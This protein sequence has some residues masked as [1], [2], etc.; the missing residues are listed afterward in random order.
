METDKYEVCLGNV[1][2]HHGLVCNGEILKQAL[3]RV[4]QCGH[5]CLKPR[6]GASGQNRQRDGNCIHVVYHEFMMRPRGRQQ[7][8]RNI[9]N[10][11]PLH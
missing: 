4:S 8:E 3:L 9:D 5:R 7:S 11:T 2:M 6:R 1:V 10:A